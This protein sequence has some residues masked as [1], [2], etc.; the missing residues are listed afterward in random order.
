MQ[1]TQVCMF[2]RYRKT[3]TP[4]QGPASCCAGDTAPA[5][6]TEAEQ[7]PARAMPDRLRS[8]A[9]QVHAHR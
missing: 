2:C 5:K 8:P 9:A 7:R 3:L 6:K 4:S 1:K